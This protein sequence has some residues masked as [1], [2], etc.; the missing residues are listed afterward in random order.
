LII[1]ELIKQ[2]HRPRALVVFGILAGV[3]VVVTLTIGLT[4]AG[5]PERIGN[6]G[7]V[8]PNSSG[9]T[10]GL[11][12][13]NALLLFLIPLAVAIFAG[14]SVAGEAGWGSLRYLLA[15]PVSRERV[16]TSKAVVAGLFSLAAVAVVVVTGVLSGLVAFGWHPLSVL[17]LQHATAF[18]TGESTLS[19][20]AALGRMALAVLVVT[21][22][23]L[24]TFA[25]A[26]LC[27]TLTDRA[28]TAV[29]G[30][31]LFGLVS[32]SLDNIPGLHALTPWLP[33]TDKG[34]DVWNGIFFRPTDWS[35]LP[36]LAL[37]QGA[38]AVV[39]LSIAAVV[40]HRRDVLS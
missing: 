3:A 23:M 12:D 25:F 15:R 28:F 6:W 2:L 5:T 9:F 24:S 7:S 40:F 36:H 29:A 18:S 19:P 30:G 38:Y 14:E 33:L 13:L 1:V 17:D 34:T 27:S 21:G 11:I 16:L 4:S 22:T 37:V 26:F 20:A 35:G 32:R 8:V 39:L 10:M 31:V